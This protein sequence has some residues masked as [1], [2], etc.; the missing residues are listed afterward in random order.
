MAYAASLLLVVLLLAFANA[1]LMDVKQEKATSNCKLI[2]KEEDDLKCLRCLFKETDSLAIAEFL[3]AVFNVRMTQGC[4]IDAEENLFASQ[5]SVSRRLAQRSR[6]R[7]GTRSGS[8][9]SESESTDSESEST[10]SESESTDSETESTDSE[11]ESTESESESTDSESESTESESES[12]ESESESTEDSTS[13]SESTE[14]T[15]SGPGARSRSNSRSTSSRSSTGRSGTGTT[16]RKRRRR[17][18]LTL[19]ANFKK[20]MKLMGQS[21]ENLLQP[22]RKMV[23]LF[24]RIIG[25]CSEQCS[26]LNSCDK[27][28]TIC[29]RCLQK[30]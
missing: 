13:E 16:S 2:C 4:I 23:L 24:E 29:V 15:S 27:D 20:Y 17:D 3:L 22:E 28:W 25:D 1:E 5:H 19:E 11:S 6:T 14:T 21:F 18:A 10:D 9:D 8:T 7:S 26:A 12:T 30:K